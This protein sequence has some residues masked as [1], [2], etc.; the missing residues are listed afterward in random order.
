MPTHFLHSSEAQYTEAEVAS[1][2]EKYGQ[3][4]LIGGDPGYDEFH[5]AMVAVDRHGAYKHVYLVGPGMMEWSAEERA[6]IKSNAQS[7]GIDTS[8]SDWQ[9]H[10]FKQGGWEKKVHNWFREYNQKGFYSA[11][12]DNLDA[13]WDQSPTEYL[14][15]LKRFEEFHENYGLAIKLMIKN[16][17]E[18]QLENLIAYKPKEGV[19]CEFGM[20]EAGSGNPTKQ[21]ALAKKLGIKAVTPKTGLKDTKTYGTGRKAVPFK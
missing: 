13:I 1:F 3:D 20:F 6:E 12:I 8:K 9:D 11:E 14:E 5:E 19:L 4:I 7:V 2:V 16:L 17:S 15:F 18:K 21:L 10:W